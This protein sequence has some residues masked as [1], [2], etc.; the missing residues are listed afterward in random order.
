MK[1]K[2]IERIASKASRL[3]DLKIARAVREQ[4]GQ[5]SPAAVA[6][7][8]TSPQAASVKPLK[9]YCTPADGKPHR[10]YGVANKWPS[11]DPVAHAAALVANG[12]EIDLI[13][14]VSWPPTSAIGN[15][16]SIFAPLKAK[17]AANRKKKILTILCVANDNHGK[18]KYGSTLGPL[19]GFRPELA[20]LVRFIE[21]IGPE[22]IVLQPATECQTTGGVWL[23]KLCRQVCKPSAG[24][25]YAWNPSAVKKC[26]G[27]FKYLIVHPGKTS[28]TKV[29]SRFIVTDHGLLIAAISDG[30]A[31]SKKFNPA[32]TANYVGECEEN[33]QTVVLYGFMHD[34]TDLAT[35]KACKAARA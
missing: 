19:D 27:T 7:A 29:P 24:W 21:T 20:K 34:A 12:F 11:I 17:I 1:N 23:E 9:A 4:T 16:A 25:A 14:A 10:G 30:G 5:K 31:M 8:A 6:A 26:P 22:G 18:R 28:I 35:L 13:E 15:V 3:V 32:K 2:Q 33:G